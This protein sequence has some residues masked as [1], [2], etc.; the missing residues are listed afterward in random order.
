MVV[1]TDRHPHALSIRTFLLCFLT[2]C[3]AI[4]LRADNASALILHNLGRAAA[5][6]DGLWQFHTGDDPA[7]ASPALDDSTWSAIEAGG[8]GR[9]RVI[10]T[11]RASPGIA[12]A[13][14][15]PPMVLMTSISPTSFRID[16]AC[17]V[18]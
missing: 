8:P 11:T 12:V 5:P 2:L 14:S 9:H 13:S 16:S 7:W 17:D 6:L 15:F 3:A 10:A 1:R 4:V 18:Y